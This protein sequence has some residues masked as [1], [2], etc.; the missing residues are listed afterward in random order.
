MAGFESAVSASC[1]TRA[2]VESRGLEPLSLLCES[3]VFP[4]DDDPIGTDGGSR[5][6]TPRRHWLLR[7]ACLP[8]SITSA[9]V[10][11]CTS[12][13]CRR[14]RHGTGHTCIRS[15]T[16]TA[17]HTV[18]LYWMSQSVLDPTAFLTMFLRTP[19]RRRDQHHVVCLST[20]PSRLSVGTPTHTHNTRVLSTRW[21]V[22]DGSHGPRP[23]SPSGSRSCCRMGLR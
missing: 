7:P 13:A 15:C 2:L 23:S 14:C 10:S 6:R 22:H 3:S 20:A 12:S 17:F 21:V 18:A 8:S 11:L 19:S 4:L 1:T 16:L 9:C 5:T